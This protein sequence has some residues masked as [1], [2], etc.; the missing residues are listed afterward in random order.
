MKYY[1]IFAIILKL[2]LRTEFHFIN[3]VYIYTLIYI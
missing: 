2:K 1:L 3:L